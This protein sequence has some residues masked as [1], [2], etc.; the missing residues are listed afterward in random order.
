MEKSKLTL[1]SIRSQLITAV[2]A[3]IALKAILWTL[4]P[5]LPYIGGAALVITVIGIAVH[6]TTR[7]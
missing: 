6:H 3:I 7:F 4:I 5:L 1:G 2:V